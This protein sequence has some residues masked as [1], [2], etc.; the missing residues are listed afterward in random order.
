MGRGKQP[1]QKHHGDLT[2]LGHTPEDK[3]QR[4]EKARDGDPRGYKFG[5][6]EAL[7][8]VDGI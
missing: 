5:I 2:A 3:R 8:K 4:K 6:E 1:E 7:V